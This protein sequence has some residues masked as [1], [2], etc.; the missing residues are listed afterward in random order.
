MG[1]CLGA[2]LIPPPIAAL[3]TDDLGYVVFGINLLA[4]A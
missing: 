3:P 2:A 1:A 4:P